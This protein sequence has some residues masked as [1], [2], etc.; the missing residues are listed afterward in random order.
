MTVYEG[1]Y[2]AAVIGHTGRGN[3]GHGLDQAFVGLPR[4]E[5]VAVADPDDAGR[6]R[7]QQRTGARATYADYHELLRRERPDVVVVGTRWPDQHEA[8]IA[9]AAEA[10]VK[11]VYVEKP[12]APSPDVADRILRVCESRNVKVTA[13]HHNRVRPAPPFA[14]RLVQEGKIGRL[15][16]V[17]TFGKCDRRSGGEDMLVL[18]FHLVD[19]MRFHAGDARWC[20]AR[21]TVNGTDATAADSHH[22][23]TE[24]LGP[25]LG[26]DV[27]ATF[28]LD[29]GVTGTF[30]STRA[31]DGGGNDYFHVELCGTAG[32]L[33]YFSDA[34]S[35]VWYLPRPFVVPGRTDA[36]ERLTPPAEADP[37]PGAAPVPAGAGGFFLSNR[38]IAAD[39]LAAIEQNRPPI[40][41]ARN[42]LAAIEMIAAVHAS[43]LSGGRV[44][45]PLDNRS[46]PLL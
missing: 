36:W 33:A 4:V 27:H 3:Y 14:A 7:A 1:A 22:S 24:E 37:V 8:M 43:H 13:A 18:G 42:A 10:G 25:L 26:D 30:E 40:N 35:P 11:G 15:R 45:L 32:I 19:L 23:Q 16:L 41:D 44:T 12:L 17:R 46:H 39:L 6:A 20:S 38:T 21:V 31:G 34:G 5:I 9:A 2:R 28:G 29:G